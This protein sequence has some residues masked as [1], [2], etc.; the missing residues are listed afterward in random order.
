MN[1]ETNFGRKK[2]LNE[3][4]RREL[5]KIYYTEPLSLREL[6]K[7]FGVSRMTVWREVQKAASERKDELAKWFLEAA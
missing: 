2:V 5:L 4:E 3:E 7:M 6:A 1:R